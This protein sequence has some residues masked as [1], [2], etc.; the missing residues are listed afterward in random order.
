MD[1][2]EKAYQGGLTES[3]RRE[4]LE[5]YKA[6]MMKQESFKAPKG[7]VLSKEDPL[8]MPRH[9][10]YGECIRFHECPLCFK[11]RNF[12][13]SDSECRSCILFEEGSICNTEKHNEKIL[14]MMIRRQRVDLD[15]TDFKLFD[16]HCEDG[17]SGVHKIIL[18]G[19]KVILRSEE[20]SDA[21][22][23]TMIPF[24]GQK[25]EYFVNNESQGKFILKDADHLGVFSLKEVNAK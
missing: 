16:V 6:G 5:Q 18:P 20:E 23:S 14:N 22:T 1:F 4:M 19:G 24:I 25:L 7:K 21:D 12:N 8:N 17:H 9:Q 13:S 2:M 3:D 15:G 11:C 10:V